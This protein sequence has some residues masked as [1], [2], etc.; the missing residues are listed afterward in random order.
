MLVSWEAENA[1]SKVRCPICNQTIPSRRLAPRPSDPLAN[2][3]VRGLAHAH[4][5]LVAID[6]D[7][8]A[9][10]D[11]DDDGARD[12]AVACAGAGGRDGA[13]RAPPAARALAAAAAPALAS[14]AQAARSSSQFERHVAAGVAYDAVAAASAA[15]AATPRGAKT[16]ER[17]NE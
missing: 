10:A 5:E 14:P 6:G 13:D 4:A 3:L 17:S 2:H 8:P 11:C 7:A 12:G 15:A 9:A 16:I 1:R